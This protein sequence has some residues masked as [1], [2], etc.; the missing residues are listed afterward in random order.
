M[1]EPYASYRIGLFFGGN[2]DF[3][4]YDFRQVG[5]HR[6]AGYI[7]GVDPEEVPPRFVP[8]PP[9]E[10]AEPYVCIAVKSTNLAKM[11]NNGHG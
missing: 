4:P 7:L 9:R 10:I 2:Q 6:T 3:Q 8:N 11:W 5:L 1:K